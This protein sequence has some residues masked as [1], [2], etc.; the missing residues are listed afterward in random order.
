MAKAN[1]INKTDLTP[2]DK[3]LRDV[4][5]CEFY[6]DGLKL[7]VRGYVKFSLKFLLPKTTLKS[8]RKTFSIEV[9]GKRFRFISE[10]EENLFYSLCSSNSKIF[11]DAFIYA[12]SICDVRK[13]EII[14]SLRDGISFDIPFPF[15][16]YNPESDSYEYKC[17]DVLPLLEEHMRCKVTCN[18][19]I[20]GLYSKFS[21]SDFVFKKIKSIIKT[22]FSKPLEVSCSVDEVFP[23]CKDTSYLFSIPS[24]KFNS[25]GPNCCAFFL[26]KYNNGYF[27][28]VK[29][30]KNGLK[31]LFLRAVPE[32]YRP[33]IYKDFTGIENDLGKI[34]DSIS[35]WCLAAAIQCAIHNVFPELPTIIKNEGLNNVILNYYENPICLYKFTSYRQITWLRLRNRMESG[36]IES[37]FYFMDP[38]IT[39]YDDGSNRS[40]KPFIT[41]MTLEDIGDRWIVHLYPHMN[42]YSEYIFIIEEGRIKHAMFFIWAYFSSTI[43][44]KREDFL[45]KE[46]FSE[47]GILSFYKGRAMSYREGIGFY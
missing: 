13:K 43:A 34:F 38:N 18:N 30:I 19:I 4:Q 1:K 15:F 22:C 41:Y 6:A 36:E 8:L 21:C 23:D 45:L 39:G 11:F 31:F 14:R 10:S 28:D 29:R 5:A 42:V 33:T 47:I 16:D 20:S 9:R 25:L 7:S 17:E 2:P 44:N 26:L 3:I 40:N 46:I 24:S 12:E 27:V 35:S 37:A 32:Q